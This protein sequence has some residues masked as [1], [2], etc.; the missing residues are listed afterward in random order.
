MPIKA[1]VSLYIGRNKKRK[2]KELKNLHTGSSPRKKRQK[3]VGGKSSTTF[4]QNT[5]PAVTQILK[6]PTLDQTPYQTG[7]LTDSNQQL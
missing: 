4:H 1:Q 7:I 5:I 2:K 3:K 6:L